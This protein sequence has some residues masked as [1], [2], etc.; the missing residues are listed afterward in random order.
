MM[1]WGGDWSPGAWLAMTVAMLA[2]WALLVWALA[3]FVRGTTAGRAR[4]M[5]DIVAERFAR[6]EIDEDEF[7]RRRDVL[8]GR[9]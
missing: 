9:S 1:W 5:E 7:A 2:F 4:D 6:G 8:R 3:V